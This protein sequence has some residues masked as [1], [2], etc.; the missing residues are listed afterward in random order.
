MAIAGGASWIVA[1]AA[2]V[3]VLPAAFPA[4]LGGELA[5]RMDRARLIRILKM[6]EIPIACC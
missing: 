1:F 5:D 6:S 4:G 3:F 2:G